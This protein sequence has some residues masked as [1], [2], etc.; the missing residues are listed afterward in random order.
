[1]TRINIRRNSVNESLIND[2]YYVFFVNCIAHLYDNDTD[3]N[4]GN[5]ASF[6]TLSNCHINTFYINKKLLIGIPR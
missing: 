1:M 2:D 6:D 4:L 5:V 3:E